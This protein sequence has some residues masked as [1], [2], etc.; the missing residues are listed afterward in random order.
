M[1]VFEKKKKTTPSIYI[2]LPYC[3][4]LKRYYLLYILGEK[5]TTAECRVNGVEKEHDLIV[6]VVLVV[7]VV[8]LVYPAAAAAAAIVQA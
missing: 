3:N 1:F 5:T 7:V 8:V 6:A 2:Y 4:L